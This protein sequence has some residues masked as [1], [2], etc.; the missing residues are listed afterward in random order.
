MASASD[1]ALSFIEPPAGG[2][3]PPPPP[4]SSNDNGL[5]SVPASITASGTAGGAGGVSAAAAVTATPPKP[6]AV[7]P[8]SPPAPP[9]GGP[10]ASFVDRVVSTE[11]TGQN[12]LSTANGTGQFIDGTW[13]NVTRGEPEVAGKTRDQILQMK[14]SD[15][16][17]A[18]R[19]VGKYAAQNKQALE[20]AGLPVN[21]GNLYLAHFFGADGAIAVLRSP[22]DTPIA[23]IRDQQ[24][25]PIGQTAL[26]SNPRLAGMT[27]GSLADFTASTISGEKG[28]GGRDDP[29]FQ[30]YQAET[31]SAIDQLS[32]Q[33]D[34]LMA[35]AE[36]APPGSAQRAFRRI[37]CGGGLWTFTGAQERRH[38][39]G[40][41]HK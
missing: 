20:T 4:P 9:P 32:T 6:A 34:K 17:F 1:N 39:L 2:T 19:M 29:A 22:P 3:S 23:A 13:L 37:G 31:R 8:A 30:Y 28:G 24:G 33:I 35:D 18:A 38:R 36:R 40:L 21:D 12:P 5:S 15:P 10:F 11:G 7:T 25:R 16:P 41:G 27:A 14:V 26:A